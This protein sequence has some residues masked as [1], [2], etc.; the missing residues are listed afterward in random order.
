LSYEDSTEI[1]DRYVE[2]RDDVTDPDAQARPAIQA[3]DI[4]SPT[5]RYPLIGD[6]IW[7]LEALTLPSGDRLIGW[8]IEWGGWH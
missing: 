7:T 4:G 2:R 1:L 6:A 3:D 8:V 5:F